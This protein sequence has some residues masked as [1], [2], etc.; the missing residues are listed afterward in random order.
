[1][2][3]L[4]TGRSRSGLCLTR[5]WPDPFGSLIFGPAADR[6][7]ESVLVVGP[8]RILVVS[9]SEL[10][11][12]KLCWILPKSTKFGRDWVKFAEI[13]PNLEEILVDF[14]EISSDLSEILMDLKEIRLNLDEISPDL[15][16][17]L[18]DLEEIRPNF[19]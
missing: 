17:I 8:S 2:L 15:N 16:E 7:K 6:W 18:V 5:D 12:S 9:R 11:F 14:D 4:F 10:E 3:G 19:D 13:W 1:M